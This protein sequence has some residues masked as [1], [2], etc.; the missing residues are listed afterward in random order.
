MM[1]EE[2]I[3]L[4]G[5][6]KDNFQRAFLWSELSKDFIRQFVEYDVSYKHILQRWLMMALHRYATFAAA[7]YQN[8][9]CYLNDGLATEK[10]LANYNIMKKVYD[11]YREQALKEWNE[12]KDV[13]I[14]ADY[15][16]RVL[17]SIVYG[18]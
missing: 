9:F 8:I 17:D 13:A 18:G 16:G 4:Q 11:M 14:Y 15:S 3:R 10:Q 12:S 5:F 1:T 6:D 7:F 2:E